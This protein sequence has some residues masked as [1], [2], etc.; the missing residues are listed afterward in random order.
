[1]VNGGKNRKKKFK[2]RK[3]KEGGVKRRI[4]AQ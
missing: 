4:L 2:L 1:M 3:D